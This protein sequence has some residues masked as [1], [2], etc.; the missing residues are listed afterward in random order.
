VDAVS[1]GSL[2][3]RRQAKDLGIKA[4]VRALRAVVSAGDGGGNT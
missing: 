4:V 1:A 3:L 2:A